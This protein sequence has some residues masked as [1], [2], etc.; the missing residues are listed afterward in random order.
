M[1][2]LKKGDGK[3][4]PLKSSSPVPSASY[5]PLC[6]KYFGQWLCH[7]PGSCWHLITQYNVTSYL[8]FFFLW[9]VL[10]PFHGGKFS[11]SV[12]HTASITCS[13]RAQWRLIKQIK[14]HAILS[15]KHK[16]LPPLLLWQIYQNPINSSKFVQM[17]CLL[18]S[19]RTHI[20][21]IT[22]YC[23]FPYNTFKHTFSYL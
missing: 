11:T 8:F 15:L 7:I 23:A 10:S 17:S 22:I 16:L 21:S 3:N 9:C 12:S 13:G 20:S 4:V 1:Q 19:F 5:F 18:G 6:Y 2:K 14:P